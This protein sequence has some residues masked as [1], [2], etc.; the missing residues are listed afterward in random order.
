MYVSVIRGGVNVEGIL[1]LVVL[2][3]DIYAIVKIVG[4]GADTLNKVIWVL[5]VL[6]LPVIG[7]IAWY[8]LG[9][10]GQKG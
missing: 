1:G 10:G 5:V 3:L 4:S 6:V 2:A 9:P 8:L 7:L